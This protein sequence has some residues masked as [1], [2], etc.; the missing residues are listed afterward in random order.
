MV[1]ERDCDVF[2]DT[3][4]WTPLKTATAI[5]TDALHVL[6]DYDGMCP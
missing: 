1:V 3:S 5:Q 4:A 6:I 2:R